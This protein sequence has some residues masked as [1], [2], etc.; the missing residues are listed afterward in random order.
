MSPLALG[1]TTY[2]W[3][4][5]AT[6][7]EAFRGLA[8]AGFTQVELTSAAPH[9]QS[10]AFG[11]F[12]RHA[13]ITELDAL[14]LRLTSVNP[15]YLDI[16]LMSP[17][18]DFRATSL[19]VMLAEIE[20][21]AD[22]GAPIV[23]LIPGRRHL[24]SPAPDAACRWWLDQALEILVT[25]GEELGVTI[26]LE[27]NPYGYIGSAAQL[28]EIADRFDSD[29]LGITYDPANTINLEDIADGVR[30]A[31]PRLK[32]AHVSDTWRDKWAHTSPGRGEVDFAA[33]AGALQEIGYTGIT[34][35]ELIDMEPPL[36]RLLDDIRTFEGYGWSHTTTSDLP[37]PK[38]R[39]R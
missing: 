13:L 25:R 35:Y 1:G 32:I 31:A 27:T 12:E 3:I 5:Q 16:N 2:S 14:G 38:P 34:I 19:K 22:L 17:S 24:L 15:G 23:V 7:I 20:L 36:P 18:N 8:E 9:L 33:Y 11:A 28:M 37:T 6:L 4:H 29:Y 30:T 21:A 10:T 26:A 39:H